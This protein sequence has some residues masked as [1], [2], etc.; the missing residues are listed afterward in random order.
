M[1]LVVSGC[2]ST[3]LSVLTFAAM[4]EAGCSCY[5]HVQRPSQGPSVRD[6]AGIQTQ[7]SYLQSWP[8]NHWPHKLPQH[9]FTKG[10]MHVSFKPVWNWSLM[11]NQRTCQFYRYEILLLY[12]LVWYSKRKKS[13]REVKS[14]IILV[15]VTNTWSE[16]CLL[17]WLRQKVLKAS[18]THSKIPQG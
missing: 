15:F 7:T 4:H 3:V 1:V 9:L 11:E 2:T 6:R 16:I 14:R 5:A 10:R 8:L 18:V 12:F 17:L 13:S